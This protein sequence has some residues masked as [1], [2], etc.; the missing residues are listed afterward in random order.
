MKY[1][2]NIVRLGG[3]AKEEFKQFQLHEVAHKKKYF[4]KTNLYRYRAEFKEHHN[5]YRKLSLEYQ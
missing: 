5:D 4:S 3:R 1:T 2:R